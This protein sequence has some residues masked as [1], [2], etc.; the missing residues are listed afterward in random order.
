M[1]DVVRKKLRSQAGASLLI[2]LLY[3]LAAMTAG[4]VVLTAASTNAG[5]LAR[6]RQEQQDYLAV[7]SAAMLVKEDFRGTAFTAGYQQTTVSS[8]DEEGNLQRDVYYSKTSPALSGE[9]ELLKNGPED[10]LAQ[11]YYSTVAVLNAPAPGEMNYSLMIAAE[12]LPDVLGAMTVDQTDGA[13]YTVTV[14]LYTQA[15]DGAHT[16]ATTL[17]FTPAVSNTRSTEREYGADTETIKTTCT[18]TV[19]WGAPIITKGATV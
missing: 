7:A 17:L 5:R 16:N 8:V 2:A 4:A 15:E 13:R 12:N 14:R 11:L 18:T 10:G 19:A 3:F 9:G 1:R 6:N